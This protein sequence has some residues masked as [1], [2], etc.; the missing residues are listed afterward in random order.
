VVGVLGSFAGFLWVIWSPLRSLRG[1]PA[2]LP[3]VVALRR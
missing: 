2:P 1:Q 3:D